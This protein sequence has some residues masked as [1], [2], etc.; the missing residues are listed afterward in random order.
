MSGHTTDTIRRSLANYSEAMLE[1]S[2]LCGGHLSLCGSGNTVVDVLRGHVEPGYGTPRESLRSL[3]TRFHIHCNGLKD[4]G[5]PKVV[6][7]S[8]TI[9]RSSFLRVVF[10]IDRPWMAYLWE[11]G[12]RWTDDETGEETYTPAHDREHRQVLTL[13]VEGAS[14]GLQHWKVKQAEIE[15]YMDAAPQAVRD[16][17]RRQIAVIGKEVDWWIAETSKPSLSIPET[18]AV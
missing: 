17:Y 16:E 4:Y 15:S 8:Y 18:S 3:A 2:E 7:P 1:L 10:Y 11:P 13:S 14:F 6:E 9:W 12:I 5:R